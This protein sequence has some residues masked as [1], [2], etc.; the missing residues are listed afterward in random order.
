MM[1]NRSNDVELDFDFNKVLEKNKDNPVFYVQYSF[2][3]ISSIFRTLDVNIDE[4]ISIN[5]KKFKINNYELATLFH[6]YWSKGNDNQEY[7]IIKNGKIKNTGT[8]IIII[9]ISVVLKRGM[10]I[11]NVSLPHKM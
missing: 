2:A 4:R 6:S 10:S 3:R 5:P 11:L 1:L 7:K 9:L 8:F